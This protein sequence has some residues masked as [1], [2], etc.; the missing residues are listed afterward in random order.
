MLIY[1]SQKEFVGIDESDLKLLGYSNLDEMLQNCSDFA[2]LFI[3]K[4]GFIHNFKNFH[5]IDFVMHADADEAK[6]IIHSNNKTFSSKIGIQT[7]YLSDSPHEKAFVIILDKIQTI[8]TQSDAQLNEA[9]ASQ[10][11]Q[12]LSTMEALEEP[13]ENLEEEASVSESALPDLSDLESH[14]LQIPDEPAEQPSYEAPDVVEDPYAPSSNDF[15]IDVNDLLTDDS[16]E[17]AS[18]NTDEEPIEPLVSEPEKEEASITIDMD[19]DDSLLNEPSI[20]EEPVK[21]SKP[22]LGDYINDSNEGINADPNYRYDPSIAADELGLPVDL[23]NEFIGDFIA[24]AHEFKD[25]LFAVNNNQDIDQ[26]RI[27]S[28]K[29]KGVAANLR[30]EDAFEVLS[31][32]NTSDDHDEINNNLIYL[33]KII[34]RLEGNEEE[35]QSEPIAPQEETSPPQAIAEPS[36]EAP[37]S[38]LE[39]PDDLYDLGLGGLAESDT[40]VVEP[41][42]TVEPIEKE[43]IDISLDFD[44]DDALPDTL[45][46]ASNEES[47]PLQS[48]QLDDDFSDL[49]LDTSDIASEEP[50]IVEPQDESID[51]DSVELEPMPS[52]DDV[53]KMFADDDTPPSEITIE[54]DALIPPM[55]ELDDVDSLLLDSNEAPVSSQES[56][57]ESEEQVLDELP[58]D[59]DLLDIGIKQPEDEPLIVN[60]VK[61]DDTLQAPSAIEN[62]STITLKQDIQK[63][64]AELGIDTLFFNEL[65]QDMKSD[66]LAQQDEIIGAI[67]NSDYDSLKEILL[68]IK[69]ASDNLRYTQISDTISDMLST[70]QLPELRQHANTLHALIEQI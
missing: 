18:P 54:D 62:P 68:S 22:M 33:F 67:D 7:I 41:Q 20:E 11:L 58:L 15:E 61:E 12:P 37:S 31:T 2:D 29:L 51:E 39:E 8:N 14:P 23:I 55:P 44:L 36:T 10:T 43:S 35:S 25:E 49:L 1:N 65:V 24:Q 21:E 13:Q 26:V 40:L 3:K 70:Q 57:I 4:P 69:G 46:N 47:E 9:I 5:W 17:D 59:D 38:T 60:S 50:P 30:I 48:S 63:Q 64:S 53:D 66:A 19:L 45:S 27:L 42:S 52:L 56:T 34:A 32:I 16:D 28:H 6:V